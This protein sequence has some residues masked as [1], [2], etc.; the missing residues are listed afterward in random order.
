MSIKP[1]LLSL[2]LLGAFLLSSCDKGEPTVIQGVVTDRKTGAPVEGATVECYVAYDVTDSGHSK[3]AKTDS[4][5]KFYFYFPGDDYYT[6]RIDYVDKTNYLTLYSPFGIQQGKEN[7]VECSIMPLDG[8]FKLIAENMSGTTDTLYYWFSIKSL[9][10]EFPWYGGLTG[11]KRAE[12]LPV[13]MGEQTI[14]WLDTPSEEYGYLYW[15]TGYFSDYLTAPFLD[16]VYLAPQDTA[17]L[18][19]QF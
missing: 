16:S 9:Q 15:G 6:L 17:E 5:G 1:N 18:V 2:C 3:Y 12:K 4:N 7:N 11:Y 14:K 19:I 10:N 13:L 8:R